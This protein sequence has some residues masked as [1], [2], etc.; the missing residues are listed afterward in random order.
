M[1]ASVDSHP[2]ILMMVMDDQRADTIHCLG[3]SDIHTPTLDSLVRS[4][5]CFLNAQGQGGNSPAVCIPSR[6]QLLTARTSFGLVEDGFT[7]PPSH[8]T[9]GET[10]RDHGYACCAAG[11]WHN[12]TA[13]LNRSFEDGKNLFFGG[14][15]AQW[16]TPVQDYDPQKRYDRTRPPV[17][18][19]FSTDVFT[20]GALDLLDQHAAR[21]DGRPLFLY[22]AL[23]SPHDP[24]EAPEE[25]RKMYHEEEL[26]LL[27]A[28]MPAHPFDN[29]EMNIRDEGLAAHPRTREEARRHLADYYAMITSHDRAIAKVLGRLKDHGMLEN[30]LVIFTSD[31]GLSLGSHGLYGKQNL[32]EE[33]MKVPLVMNGPGVPKGLQIT[34][35]AHHFSLFPT[36]CDLLG[37]PIPASVH[38]PSLIPL[39][40]GKP[41][42]TRPCYGRYLGLMRSVKNGGL[43]LIEYH[44][45][46]RRISQ[47]F[48]LGKDPHEE[49]D[50]ADD[51]LYRTRLREMR[52]L[53]AAERL[54]QG[55]EDDRFWDGWNRDRA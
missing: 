7:I 9:L 50:L 34:Q 47:L 22:L 38:M 8:T 42:D 55:D 54:H 45:K 13:S 15:H 6:A 31:H 46:G 32:Y 26:S 2:N 30:T 43:K 10:L 1:T 33:S 19:E 39:L 25:F 52:L 40:E 29:G 21:K 37:I 44:V 14:M 17:D 36:L 49:H 41:W 24:K 11:K 51:P 27:P 12:D 53:L 16:T 18:P 5:T 4:G 48:D 28:F 3:N 20:R 23:T 35:P